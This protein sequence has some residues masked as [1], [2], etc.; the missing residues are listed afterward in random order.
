MPGKKQINPKRSLEAYE[1]WDKAHVNNPPVGLVT[2]ETDPDA[3]QMKRYAARLADKA[4]HTAFEVSLLCYT[5]VSATY[6]G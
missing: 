4:E 1:P 2:P 3:G 6:G 5:S